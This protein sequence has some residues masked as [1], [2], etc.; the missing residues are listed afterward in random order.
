MIR[1]IMG[2]L[3]VLLVIT[4]GGGFIVRETIFPIKDKEIIIK[5]AKEYKVDPALVAAVINFETNFD[6]IE[7]KEG[8]ACGLMKLTDST[9]VELSK[10]IGYKDFKKE[11]IAQNDINIKLGTYYLSKSNGDTLENQVG[12]W[13]IRNGIDK[14]DKLDIKAYA[15][16]YYT[17]KI[18][19]REKI[20]KILY[21]TFNI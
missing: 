8:K 18:A 15:K 4:I 21:F 5:H 2:I 9:G 19:T 16:E 14:S 3:I 7:Y 12:N 17:D 6:P 10:E 20:Y 1:K 13:V 11:K